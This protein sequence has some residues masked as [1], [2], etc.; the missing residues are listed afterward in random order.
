MTRKTKLAG[1]EDMDHWD[2]GMFEDRHPKPTYTPKR[3]WCWW[4]WRMYGYLIR[5]PLRRAWNYYHHYDLREPHGWV[6]RFKSSPKVKEWLWGTGSGKALVKLPIRYFLH[7]LL[8]DSYECPHCGF[9]AWGEDEIFDW[10][11]DG[12][13]ILA[14]KLVEVVDSGGPGMEGDYWSNGWKW[15]YRCGYHDWFND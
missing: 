15:C 6:P 4:F 9:H 12:D 3:L 10:K 5:L 14:D 2:W 8:L 7:K 11:A 13:K 1:V